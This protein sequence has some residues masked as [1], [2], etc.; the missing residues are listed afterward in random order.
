[1]SAPGVCDQLVE[2]R[3]LTATKVEIQLRPPLSGLH[4]PSSN[5]KSPW[6][7]DHDTRLHGAPRAAGSSVA[8]RGLDW[9][10][11]VCEMSVFAEV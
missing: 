5:R 3:G 11:E 4:N 9:S 7:E 10:R 1:M 2:V 6:C 8:D